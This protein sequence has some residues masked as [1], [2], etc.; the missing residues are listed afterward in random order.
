MWEGRTRSV[1]MTFGVAT[2][3]RGENIDDVIRR[4]D[5]ALLGAKRDGKNRVA[6]AFA[7]AFL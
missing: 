7:T 2:A 6:R 5:T 4:A 3:T 1:T